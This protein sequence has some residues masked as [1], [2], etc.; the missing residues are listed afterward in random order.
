MKDYKGLYHN[1]EDKTQLYE[2]GAHF[3]YE[4]LYNYLKE[5]QLKQENNEPLDKE[6]NIEE[7]KN[8][9]KKEIELPKKRKKYK[10]KTHFKSENKRYLITDTHKNDKERNEFS[11]IEEEQEN[12]AEEIRKNNRFVTKS[13]DKIRLP[14]ISS[15]SII[16][17]QKSNLHHNTHKLAESQE[18]PNINRSRDFRT[19]SKRINF[20]K[21]NS[22]HLENIKENNNN[23]I[24]ETQSIFQDQDNGAIKIFND[25]YDKTSKLQNVS[26]HH[27][28]KKFP[29]L[30]QLSQDNEEKNEALPRV[31]RKPNKLLSIFEKEKKIKN[32][33][34][35][36]NLFLG[37]KSNYINKEHRDIMRDEMAQQIHNL[38][39]QLLGFPNKNL[40]GLYQ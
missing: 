33:N 10:M 38:K 26:K 3:K 11:I 7:I 35:N 1:T 27:K 18:M 4:E 12:K 14:Q 17:L 32:S 30:Y 36:N 34:N 31:Q 2:F 29:K 25:S 15:K 37:E 13:H 20:P 9:N 5:L 40:K 28:N 6:S 21:L 8:E 22:L 16:S 19:K 23:M 24:V 39:K